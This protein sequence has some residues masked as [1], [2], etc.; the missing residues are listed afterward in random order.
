MDDWIIHT[1]YIVTHENL[2]TQ[3]KKQKI[4]SKKQYHRINIVSVVVV[5]VEY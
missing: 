5:W 3:H 1:V 2:L 4:T